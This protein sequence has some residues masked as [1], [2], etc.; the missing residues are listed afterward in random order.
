MRRR[1][2]RFIGRSR[3]LAFYRFPIS[4]SAFQIA[5]LPSCLVSR[6]RQWVVVAYCYAEF[7]AENG[8]A[9]DFY[10]LSPARAQFRCNFIIIR[11]GAVTESDKSPPPPPLPPPLPSSSKGGPAGISTRISPSLPRGRGV[12]SGLL[13]ADEG[14]G[15]NIL[16]FSLRAQSG[17]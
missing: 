3:F 4:R 1:N 11:R 7:A 13:P 16:G 17:H 10:V 12:T 6:I 8:R 15:V 14:K 5:P 2:G 9:H